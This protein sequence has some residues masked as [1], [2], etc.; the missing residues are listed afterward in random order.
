MRL[1]VPGPEQ[2]GGPRTSKVLIVVVTLLLVIDVVHFRRPLEFGAVTTESCSKARIKSPSRPK[3]Y[4][5]SK[6]ESFYLENGRSLGLDSDPQTSSGC[7]EWTN[8]N[9]PIAAELQAYRDG[10]EAYKVALA[11]FLQKP[12]IKDLRK[13][14]EAN[15]D[16]SVCDSLE[17]HPDGL[18]GIFPLNT[19][20]QTADSLLEPLFPPMRSPRICWDFGGALMSMEYLIH[21]FAAYCRKLTPSSRIVLVDMGASLSFHGTGDQPAVYLTDIY[22]KFGFHFDHIYAYE[23]T[24]TKPADM[25]EKVP[26]WMAAAYHWINVGVSPDPNSKQNPWRMLLQEYDENDFSEYKKHKGMV[27]YSHMESRHL[28]HASTYVFHDSHCQVG[29][30]HSGSRT[31]Y[32]PAT[33]RHARTTAAS[34]CL[35]F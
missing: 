30:R 11:S 6:I 35:L 14:I 29:Y 18:N 17:L 4:A 24:P 15:G 16:H 12:S 32:G 7:T 13:E 3:T 22:S 2:H 20:T 9:S 34:R 1:P 28:T 25:V 31:A 21:D 23:I 33:R 10:I 5:A 8:P 27:G 26:D 19:L